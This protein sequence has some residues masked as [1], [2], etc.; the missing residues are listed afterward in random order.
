MPA[1]LNISPLE[2]GRYGKEQASGA[3]HLLQVLQWESVNLAGSWMCEFTY[4]GSTPEDVGNIPDPYH[5]VKPYEAR[6]FK[7]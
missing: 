7:L 1:N 2:P 4:S 6:W 3:K 5:V